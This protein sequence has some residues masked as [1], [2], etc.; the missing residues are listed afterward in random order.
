[1]SLVRKVRK[2]GSS[3]IVTIPKQI[4]DFYNIQENDKVEFSQVSG[5][6][7]FEKRLVI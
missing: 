7:M 6:I 1:M 4:A 2:V 3:L 5:K